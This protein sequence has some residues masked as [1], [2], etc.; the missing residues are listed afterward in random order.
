MNYPKQNKVNYL[1][2][3]FSQVEAHRLINLLCVCASF[4]LNQLIKQ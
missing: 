3:Q 4:V 1:P 2:T